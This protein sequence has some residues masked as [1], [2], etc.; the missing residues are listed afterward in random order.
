VA[1]ALAGRAKLAAHLEVDAIY[2]FIVAGRIQFAKDSGPDDWWQLKLARTHVQMLATSF[3]RHG[4]LPFVDDVVADRGVLDDYLQALPRP[5]RL[6]VLDP[7]VDGVLARDAARHKHVASGWAYLAQ[8][9]REALSGIGLWL[10]TTGLDVDRTILE[11]ERRWDEA[12]LAQ[13]SG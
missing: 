11:I 1:H 9:M 3:A 12:L 13:A 4:V 8:P 6:I 2:D 5:V 7:A 10:D